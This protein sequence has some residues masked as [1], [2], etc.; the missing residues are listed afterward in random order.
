LVEC[1]APHINISID[2]LYQALTYQK[3]MQGKIIALTNGLT[4]T[5]FEVDSALKRLSVMEEIPVKD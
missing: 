5:Y 3:E 1:K 4:H 2:T